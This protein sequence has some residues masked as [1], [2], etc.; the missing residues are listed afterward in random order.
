MTSAIVASESATI[1]KAAIRPAVAQDVLAQN[2]RV[3]GFSRV[4][5]DGEGITQANGYYNQ[6]LSNT[7]IDGYHAGISICYDAC[8]RN[9]T[10]STSNGNNVYVNNNLVSNLMQG[11]TSDG[12]SIYF[13]VGGTYNS[14]TGDE[15]YSNVVY[16]TTDSYIIDVV[17]GSRSGTGYGGEGI[18]LDALTANVNVENNVVFNVDGNA[19]H[20][21]E[22]LTSS[23]E[24]ANNFKNNIFAFGNQGMFT[25]NSP[26]PAGCP[27]TPYRQVELLDNLFVFDVKTDQPQ[28][29]RG[30]FRAIQGCTDSCQGSSGTYSGYQLFQGNDYWSDAET[31]S[32]VSDAFKIQQNQSQS[33][34]TQNGSTYSCSGASPVSL[35][36]SQTANNWQTGTNPITMDED[37]GSTIFDP[38]TNNSSF[39]IAGTLA[40]VPNDFT[41]SNGAGLGAF[42]P[43]FTNSA[44]SG[45]G[46]TVAAPTTT[47]SSVTPATTVCPT[48]PTYVYGISSG[49]NMS[50]PF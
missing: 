49:V 48:F 40:N 5:A 24:T 17:N 9:A 50:P 41:I 44:I 8:G 38:T 35:Y 12:G 14:A 42:N 19:I 4:L 23:S 46:S 25:Q 43:T 33:G 34:L 13:N 22:G 31:W 30:P 16:D 32:S 18:Y 36:F 26:W 1:R 29:T 27:S 15:I 7:V 21:T 3:T 10:T 20:L 39:P 45:A 47:C 6:V 2:N 28:P 11:V 37:A